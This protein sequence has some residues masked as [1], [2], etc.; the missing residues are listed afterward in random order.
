M[1]LT[2]GTRLVVCHYFLLVVTFAVTCG[3][4]SEEP[5]RGTVQGRVTV[6]GQ[7]LPRG[8]ILFLPQ[9]PPGPAVSAVI[10]DG[11]YA[12]PAREGPLVGQNRVEVE[13]ELNLGFALDDE[14]AFAQRQGA[15]LPP[16]P[17]PPQFNRQSALTTDI[18]VGENTYDVTI[19]AIQ[20]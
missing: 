18:K 20:P 9:V 15:P 17:I 19:P 16:N 11:A 7:P 5:S 4:G 14:Q 3:C 8:R 13:G 2:F 6:G 12:L 10:Q 1:T